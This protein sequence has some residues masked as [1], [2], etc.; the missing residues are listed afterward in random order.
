MMMKDTIIKVNTLENKE[1]Q[2]P[3]KGQIASIKKAICSDIQEL[4]I[5]E[6]MDKVGNK[7]FS[8]NSCLMIEGT[9]NNNFQSC[10]MIVLD[11]DKN[12]DNFIEFDNIVDTSNIRPTFGY[13]K[14]DNI[15]FKA[16]FMLPTTLYSPQ[17][18]NILEGMLNRVFKLNP[19]TKDINTLHSGGTEL[20]IPSLN[21]YSGT[22]SDI[23]ILDIDN[24]VNAFV[25]TLEEEDKVNLTHNIKSFCKQQGLNTVNGI[26]SIIN[27]EHIEGDEEIQGTEYNNYIFNLCSSDIFNTDKNKVIGHKVLNT[28]TVSSPVR[29]IN[30]LNLQDTCQLF[31]KASHDQLKNDGGKYLSPEEIRHLTH[32]LRTV[33]GY[34]SH[35]NSIL[36]DYNYTS[37]TNKGNLVTIANK[38]N[39]KPT[40]CS[41]FNCRY[42]Y[43][44][45][46]NSTILEKYDRQTT[47]IE[48]PTFRTD[49]KIEYIELTEAEKQLQEIIAKISENHKNRVNGLTLVKCATG[50]GKTESIVNMN[51][52][53]TVIAVANHQLGQELYNRVQ[54]AQ[55]NNNIVY[56][57]PLNMDNL[58]NILLDKIDT[59][60]AEGRYH[61][62]DKE[63]N[64]HIEEHYKLV[65][66]NITD[67]KPQY[68]QDIEDYLKGKQDYRTNSSIIATHTRISLGTGGNTN[69]TRLVVDEDCINTFI[70]NKSYNYNTIKSIYNNI[71]AYI[72]S[73]KDDKHQIGLEYINKF[74]D[75]LKPNS[76]WTNNILLEENENGKQPY[77][78]VKKIIDSYLNNRAKRNENIH[79]IN[80]YE[81]FSTQAIQLQANGEYYH[82]VDGNRLKE[83]NNYEQVIILS[84]T[85]DEDIH[86]PLLKQ[87]TNK[88]INYYDIAEVKLVGNIKCYT[89]YSLSREVFKKYNE[90]KLEP[91]SKLHKAIKSIEDNTYFNPFISFKTENIKCTVVNQKHQILHFGNAEGIDKYK[92]QSIGV[93]GTPHP[94]P[95]QMTGLF[96]L[97]NGKN[98]VEP[99]NWKQQRVTYGEWEFTLNTYSNV[100]DK[101]V[102]SIHLYYI[103]AELTQAVGRARLLRK[104]G[105][106]SV[107]S[108]FPLNQCKLVKY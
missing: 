75:S 81:F 15:G 39:Y 17:I 62:V 37:I 70:T 107:F 84:A 80:L 18:K 57:K 47:R 90:N 31:S 22:G 89:S 105:E 68:I 65:G 4:E 27:K 14:L 38:L 71:T 19:Q 95:V 82:T 36:K 49:K 5:G 44:C 93:I 55:P 88:N 24:L 13:K 72:K 21:F 50:L 78:Y 32:N 41:D 26:P 58:P 6:F 87:Y 43:N 40:K 33:Q 35:L 103:Y 28:K 99:L 100:E 7:A 66:A 74:F 94:S 63:L 53:N 91:K 48:N 101:A 97:I 9:K 12:E 10:N 85:L 106:V 34:Q 60:R 79:G 108:N 77:V 52:E 3:K 20:L 29:K 8:F 30:L 64:R 54:E 83:L 51:L 59:Y 45:M 104:P 98:P 2:E 25:S 11:F 86:V 73:M 42:H 56:I 23:N 102:I 92:G 16:I 67:I 46:N 69:I 61:L 96:F 76:I 1:Q